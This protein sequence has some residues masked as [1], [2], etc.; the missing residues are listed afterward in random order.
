MKRKLLTG[1]I[2]LTMTAVTGIM[3]LTALRYSMKDEKI[4]SKQAVHAYKKRTESK[5]KSKAEKKEKKKK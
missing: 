4:D 5:A 2:V 3:V 1:L